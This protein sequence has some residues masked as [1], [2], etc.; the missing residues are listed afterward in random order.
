[1]GDRSGF[2]VWKGGS[3][4]I[5][6]GRVGSD[7]PMMHVAVLVFF[8]FFLFPT[9]GH[10]RFDMLFYTPHWFWMFCIFIPILRH[11]TFAPI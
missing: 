10:S 6:R 7:T 4:V 2:S 9:M 5:I 11:S 1:V 8:H 3:F